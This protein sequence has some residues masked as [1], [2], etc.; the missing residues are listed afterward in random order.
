MY[1]VSSIVRSGEITQPR[2]NFFDQLCSY[3]AYNINSSEVLYL[4][5]FQIWRLQWVGGGGESRGKEQNQLI[6]DMTVTR[7]GGIKKSENLADIIYGSPLTLRIVQSV[8]GQVREC[9]LYFRS[10]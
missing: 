1:T 6:C 5:G 9:T 8:T 4:G 2:T 3:N 10:S 7:G